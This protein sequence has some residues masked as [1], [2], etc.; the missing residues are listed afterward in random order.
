MASCIHIDVG[1]SVLVYSASKKKYVAVRQILRFTA[2]H[3]GTLHSYIHLRIGDRELNMYDTIPVGE[4][5]RVDLLISASECAK[6]CG[7][8]IEGAR[9]I[10]APCDGVVDR[11]G[12]H[13]L[14]GS[15]LSPDAA[16]PPG[17]RWDGANITG[18]IFVDVGNSI[19]TFPAGDSLDFGCDIVRFLAI[20]LG[21]FKP[22]SIYMGAWSIPARGVPLAVGE[23]LLVELSVGAGNRGDDDAALLSRAGFRVSRRQS[24][25]YYASAA[26][27]GSLRRPRG[28]RPYASRS[29]HQGV[30]KGFALGVEPLIAFLSEG[31]PHFGR[32]AATCREASRMTRAALGRSTWWRRRA[33]LMAKTREVLRDALSKAECPEGISEIRS[34]AELVER[35]LGERGPPIWR[36]RVFE[37]WREN[38]AD[39][40]TIWP[41]VTSRGHFFSPYISHSETDLL[42]ALRQAEGILSSCDRPPA[43][44]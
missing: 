27:W 8:A 42:L 13:C 3:L 18:K 21:I 19:L 43:G 36:G 6:R 16:C 32:V 4:T 2:L 35:N 39:A 40:H 9:C 24:L 26:S 14:S 23:T 29:P 22:M 44:A 28:V 15:F 33:L 30:E 38:M 31:R 12:R 11:E 10:G 7:K 5:V 34:F 1:S 17:Q 20:C 37:Y 25:S 41:G